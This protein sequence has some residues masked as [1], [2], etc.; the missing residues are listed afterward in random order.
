M[1]ADTTP[2]AHL[3]QLLLHSG[4]GQSSIE[5]YAALDILINAYDGALLDTDG[6]RNC[7]TIDGPRAYIN[8]A[9]LARLANDI[10]IHIDSYSWP[11]GAS[12]A[13]VIAA[14]LATGG[15]TPSLAA[16][17]SNSLALAAGPTQP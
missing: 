5:I 4:I 12:V 3:R 15:I 8:W 7:I 6:V 17:L 14:S 1:P 13:L 10:R 11:N 9:D 2:T 16:A